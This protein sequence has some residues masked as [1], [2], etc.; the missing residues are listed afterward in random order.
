MTLHD[1]TQLPAD[2]PV[3][4]DDGAARHL[5][6][7]PMPGLAL[8]STGG[9]MV[10]LS[11]VTG[12]G[13]RAVLFFYPRTGIPGQP[14]SKGHGGETW[15][16]IPGARG[17]TPQSCSFRDLHEEFSARG[18]RV[19]GVSTNTT[20]HQQEFKA[21]LHIPFDFLSDRELA[22][23]RR[24]CL[25]TFE[26]P[27]ESGGPGTLMRRMA[28][29]VER[30]PEGVT[31]IRHV[32]YPVFPP[33]RNAQTVLAWIQRRD[34]LVL[35]P[36]DASNRH[37]VRAELI[38]HWESTE[39]WSRGVEYHAD[40]LPGFVASTGGGPAGHISLAFEEHGAPPRECE[41]VTLSA[42]V[43]GA[44]AGSRLLEA[45]EDAARAR[46]CRRIFLTTTND[47][48]RALGF[49]QRRGWRMSALLRGMMDRY[50]AAGKPVPV[51]GN[52]G[53]AVRD[54]IELELEL[55][56]AQPPSGGGGDAGD[57]IPA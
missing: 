13:S 57:I 27:V 2:L 49:Y 23:T 7:L 36:T 31:R 33:D 35:E 51:I 28:W 39:I 8:P 37:F 25:P 15:E 22:L 47:N 18:V 44:G 56:S 54:E 55:G 50:R 43:D 14:A 12:T 20:E 38:K 1:P 16:S 4:S 34:G 48:L 45:A 5:V 26:F 11:E 52:N 29:F 30:D 41:V 42:S 9:E 21:R 46:G 10:Q 19:W 6:R 24:L 53:L 3:P 32:W 17:C 40:M